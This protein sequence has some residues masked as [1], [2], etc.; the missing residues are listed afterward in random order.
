MVTDSAAAPPQGWLEDWEGSGGFALV[1]MPVLIGGQLPTQ[2][3]A[4]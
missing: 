2:D 3:E 1:D 4:E